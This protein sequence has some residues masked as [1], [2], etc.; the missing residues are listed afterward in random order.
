MDWND[1]LTI[2]I[3]GDTV[4]NAK[5]ILGGWFIARWW[6]KRHRGEDTDGQE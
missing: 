3:A 4:F 6:R 1:L 5:L 2:L